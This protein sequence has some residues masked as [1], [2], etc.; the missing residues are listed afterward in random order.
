MTAR[1]NGVEISR[2]NWK[3]LYWSFGEMLA[4]ASRGVDLHPGD[5]IGSGTVGTGCILE[6][7][8]EN[9]GGWLAPGDRLELE[10]ERLGVLSATIVNPEGN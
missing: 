8:P 4:R 3:D 6:L 10:I 2:G 1:R 9:A 5:V 7:R